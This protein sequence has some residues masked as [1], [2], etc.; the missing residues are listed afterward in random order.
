MDEA[1]K[2][3]TEGRVAMHHRHNV[4]P[5]TVDLAMDIALQVL[6][7]WGG[8]DGITV[9]VVLDEVVLID[10]LWC[11]EV[12]Q[13]IAIRMTVASRA[14]VAECIEHTVTG[15]HA[16]GD[17]QILHQRCAHTEPGMSHG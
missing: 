7:G 11:Q 14:D 3:M 5:C 15:E 6:L 13:H 10:Q 2:G 1:A 9:E 8:R 12:G 17:H 4:G 16:V